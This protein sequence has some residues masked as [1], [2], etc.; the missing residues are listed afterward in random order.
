M[1]QFVLKTCPSAQVA[2]RFKS[3]GTL[4]ERPVSKGSQEYGTIEKEWPLT[5]PITK[6]EALAQTSG[7]NNVFLWIYYY[8][9]DFLL[10]VKSLHYFFLHLLCF[11]PNHF[12]IKTINIYIITTS[13]LP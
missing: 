2:D 11:V 8:H 9:L 5:Q 3:G 4:L 7:D 10:K 1:S 6:L 12:N 13:I